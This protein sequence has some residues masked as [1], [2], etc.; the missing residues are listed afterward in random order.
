[1][2]SSGA[3]A[4][5]ATWLQNGGAGQDPFLWFRLVTGAPVTC[6]LQIFNNFKSSIRASAL[7]KQQCRTDLKGTRDC[8]GVEKQE[9]P[10]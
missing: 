9:T 7:S 6:K 10:R 5:W 2:W 1:M 4:A 8:G 3:G